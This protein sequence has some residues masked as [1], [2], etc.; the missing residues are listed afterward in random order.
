M[1]GSMVMT[2]AADEARSAPE[3]RCI[4]TR[5]SMPRDGLIRFVLGPDGSVVP[6]LAET[7]PGRGVWVGS[8][9]ELVE[10]ARAKNLFAGA[11]RAPAK[12]QAD[13]ATRIERLLA[14]R[15]I[16]HIGL[17]RRADRIVAGREA[18]RAAVAD[19][20][21]ALLLAAADSEGRDRAELAARFA[22]ERSAV[23]TSE[24]IGRALGRTGIVHLGLRPGRLAA[25]LSRDLRRLAGFRAGR[26]ENENA[27]GGCECRPKE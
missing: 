26:N 19:R 5:R 16:A 7:L 13:L 2:R 14:E 21:L 23:L 11:F 20:S 22:G 27:Q 25:A 6:D 4:V 3:R 10:T 24:E 18:V 1:M 12:A 15:C 9:R 17:A 8:R